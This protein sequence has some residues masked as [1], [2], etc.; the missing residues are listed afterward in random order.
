MFDQSSTWQRLCGNKRR[1]R[2]GEAWRP[3]TSSGRE[4][5]L[6]SHHERVLRVHLGHVPSVVEDAAADR[7]GRKLAL[8]LAVTFHALL[9]LVTLP[10]T[11]PRELTY[12]GTARA[13]H[14]LQNVRFQA[15]PSAPAAAP[16]ARKKKVRRIPIPDPTPDAPEP[17]ERE[18]DIELD[19]V[20]DLEVENVMFDLPPAPEPG[21]GRGRGGVGS[22]LRGRGGGDGEGPY[23]LSGDI[24]KPVRIHAVPVRYTE[25]ARKADIQG[26]VVLEAVI[27]AAGDVEEVG[28]ILGQPLGLT[29]NAIESVL[30]WKYEPALKDGKPVAVIMAVTITFQIQ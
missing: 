1:P 23:R 25:E 18:L 22:G 6:G 2:V 28:V 16:P 15:P 24:Q 21:T 5:Q 8:V 17:I 30:Q 26:V 29:E 19:F 11:R 4:I 12:E 9:L 10:A 14:L 13:V 27:T 20:D 7:R 3:I